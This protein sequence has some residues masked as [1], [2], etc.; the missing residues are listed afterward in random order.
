VA[1]PTQASDE[2]PAGP[3]TIRSI[4]ATL[5]IGVGDRATLVECGGGPEVRWTVTALPEQADAYLI[6]NTANG[7]CLDVNTGARDDGVAILVYDCHRQANQQWRIRR[8]GDGQVELI[9]VGTEKCIDV[10]SQAGGPGT[11]LQ[12]WSCHGGPNQRWTFSTG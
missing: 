2:I 10:P 4:S 8:S 5:C 3:A 12:Q 7:K 9:S 6:T 11:Q 1:Q